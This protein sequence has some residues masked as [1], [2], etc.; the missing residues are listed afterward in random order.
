[1]ALTPNGSPIFIQLGQRPDEAGPPISGESTYPDDVAARLA[2][3]A[4]EIIARY[5]QPRSALLPLLHLVQSEDGYL[6][7]AGIAFCA[8]QLGLTDAEVTAVA[9]FYSMYRR[10]PTGDYLV[11]V[12]TNTLCAIM[13]GD[14]ILE[15]LQD[16]LGIHAGETTDDGR[17]TLEHVECNAAC[18][19]APVVMVNWEFFDNQT[20]S[21]ARDLVDSLRT[22]EP[23]VPTRGAPLCTFRQTARVLAGLPDDR[24]VTVPGQEPAATLAGLR[25]AR[26]LGMEAPS[27]DQG[28]PVPAP[29]L[30][31]TEPAAVETTKDEPAPGP[32][33][34][35]PPK[36][37]TTET[38]PS[39]TD[40][41]D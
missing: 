40:S 37:G 36:P 28:T 7:K 4:K 30:D 8:N 3:S 12:C 10:E 14:A 39:T 20:P 38:D 15:A 35:V 5:P 16:H 6:T 13:G 11:G 21:S 33:A 18:D 22:G 29:T 41:R 1:M 31:G 34:T 25:V 17:V 9:T 26:R 19:Y 32:S 2:E 24:P 23:V 27:P